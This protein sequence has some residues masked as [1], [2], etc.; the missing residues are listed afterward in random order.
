MT[1]PAPPSSSCLRSL[2]TYGMAVVPQ[3]RLRRDAVED[4]VE[5]GSP[6]FEA[7]AP[8]LSQLL[9]AEVAEREVRSIAYHLRAA[10]FP[11]Y[12]DLAGFDFAASEINEPLVRQ[13][14][15]C[16]FIDGAHNV[17]LIGGLGGKDA[18]IHSGAGFD[19][20]GKSQECFSSAEVIADRARFPRQREPGQGVGASQAGSGSEDPER[21][22]DRLVT[23]MLSARPGRADEG[24]CNAIVA[25]RP[26]AGTGHE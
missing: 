14:H 23:V 16:E 25:A 1:P 20:I 10:R 5:Q 15:R 17:V 11:A 12:K 13:L 9:K 8:I 26:N 6:A 24:K 3:A 4:L 7:A 18:G 21:S 22:E 2:K 19:A